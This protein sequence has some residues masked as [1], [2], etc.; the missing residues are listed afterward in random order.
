MEV[1][2]QNEPSAPPGKPRRRRS[3]RSNNS[4]RSRLT[5]A[6]VIPWIVVGILWSVGCALFAYQAVYA[7]QVASGVRQLS[8]PA[9]AA[10]EEV[11]KE[12]LRSVEVLSQPGLDMTELVDQQGRTDR[13]IG[14]MNA[15]ASELLEPA[16]DEIRRP[17][18][19]LTGYFARMS[20]I[21]SKVATK[22]ATVDEIDDFYNGLF[23]TATYLADMQAR[24]IPDPETLQGVLTATDL[25]RATDMLSREASLVGT[26]L[27]NGQMTP[28]Q[29]RQIARYIDAHHTTMEQSASTLLPNVRVRY[30]QM[31][32][33]PAW[34][35]LIA[36]E[37]RIIATPGFNKSQAPVKLED[38]RRITN[39]VGSDMSGL[40]YTQADDVSAAGVDNSISPLW[41]VLWGSL[42]AL[43]VAVVSFVF[44]RRVYR[45]V[46]DDALLTRLQGLR[47]ESLEMAQKLPDVV[48]R[49]RNGEPVDMQTEMV[50]LEHYGHDEVGQVAQAIR[51]F[52]QEAVEAAVGETRARQG[53]RVVF[54]G[55]A[56]R[57]QR[58]LR[59]MHGTID[60]LERNE[61]NSAQL[62][63]LF[64]LDNSTTRARRTVENLLVL[65]DQQ[66]GRRWSRPVAL[67][68]VLRSSVSEIDQ[69]S[70]VVI[71]HVPEVMISGAAVGDT[72][73]LIS[74]LIDNATAFS[75]PTTQVH[76]DATA[77][78]RGIAIDIADQGLGMEAANR[79]HANSMMSEPPE[80]DRLVLENNK[81]EQLGLFTAAR[82]A[83]RRDITVKFGVSA[84]GGT[85]ATVLL[86]DRILD[87]E[88]ALSTSN[89]SGGLP[90]LPTG[91][92]AGSGAKHELDAP[93]EVPQ[94]RELSWNGAM[95]DQP[96]PPAPEPVETTYEW[97]KSEIAPQA[98]PP[99]FE[100]AS[101]PDPNPAP[102]PE[103]PAE[104]RRAAGGRPALPKR[105]PQTHLVEGLRDDPDHEEQ[106]VI[107]SPTR[108]AG[109]RRAFRG[110]FDDAP[111]DRS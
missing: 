105:V 20:D 38:W 64:D 67:M 100:P 77:V 75:P 22:Q 23:D 63:K 109:F 101:Q 61:E 10:L 55:M 13:A 16:P 28:E 37:N 98:D 27:S 76:V 25:F 29:H 33:S 35:E 39:Q 80:F 111:G 90:G 83:H 86:P 12:R 42:G 88:N 89:G 94:S 41:T 107:A 34:Q 87:A 47:S 110:G 72:I 97:P 73:H 78:A 9:M 56:Y 53:A 103:P 48:R 81:A 1:T 96:T 31:L 68:D 92:E 45:T 60:Q 30:E 108:L 71:G 95:T 50:V 58:L 36:A 40:V 2:T 51:L 6:V 21:R 4:I 17:M 82:L 66:P 11:K 84:Y 52:Q 24:I 62:A 26:A 85:R 5:W 102:L 14:E 79:D 91:R 70:R 99:R 46:V 59:H 32:A 65:G 44:S 15:V 19:D 104:R 49:L 7:Q 54:V 93:S 3:E 69:Y 18:A 74:E 43:A 106:A 57:I 8:L